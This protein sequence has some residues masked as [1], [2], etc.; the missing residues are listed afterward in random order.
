[1]IYHDKLTTPKVV[2]GSLFTHKQG[3]RTRLGGV[4]RKIENIGLDEIQVG[5]ISQ[6]TFSSSK[7]ARTLL[8]FKIPGPRSSLLAI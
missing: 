5:V 2:R 6:P 8:N 3:H 7:L 4:G 1:M